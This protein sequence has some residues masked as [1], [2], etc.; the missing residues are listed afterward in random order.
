MYKT[1]KYNLQTIRTY[2]YQRSCK[3]NILTLDLSQVKVF[4]KNQV[5]RKNGFIEI[6]KN[7]DT[8]L[9]IILLDYNPNNYIEYSNWLLECQNFV[10]YYL[11]CLN[12]L[13]NCFQRN[14]FST[15]L[16]SDLYVA[17]FLDINF[18]QLFF[19]CINYNKSIRE[20]TKISH[21]GI[22]LV[23]FWS[24]NWFDLCDRTCWNPQ[25]EPCFSHFA[26]LFAGGTNFWRTK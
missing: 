10:Q 17:K 5:N 14:L 18:Q 9:K 22:Y 8:D 1:I 6:P 11:A 25:I 7:L 16:F 15:K 2:I 26:P 12:F 21:G 4:F 23:Y 13:H 20:H 3:S 24:H 19:P